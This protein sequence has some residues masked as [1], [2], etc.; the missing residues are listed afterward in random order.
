[1][2]QNIVYVSIFHPL[3]SA[4]IVKAG[5]DEAGMKQEMFAN[6]LGS[7]VHIW[8]D[9]S[10]KAKDQDFSNFLGSVPKSKSCKLDWVELELSGQN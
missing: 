9:F 4:Y 5:R 8:N 1:V 6:F 7:K 3:T 10:K 2:Y